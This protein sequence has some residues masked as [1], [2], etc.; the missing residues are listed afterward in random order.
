MQRAVFL[1]AAMLGCAIV[2]TWAE[3]RRSGI[4][5]LHAALGA[6]VDLAAGRAILRMT[7]KPS[8]A[9]DDKSSK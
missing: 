9:D 6:A 2:G 4:R 1:L 3:D 7:D 5:P 8:A